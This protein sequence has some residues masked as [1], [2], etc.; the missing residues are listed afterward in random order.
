MLGLT[1]RKEFQGRRLKGTAIELA[2]DK[3]TGATQLPARDFLDITY[4]T[5]DVLKALEAIGPAQGRPLV[6]IG[7]RGQGK[8]HVMGVLYHALTDTAA[9]KQWLLYWADRLKNEKIASFS[10]REDMLVLTESLHRQRYKFLWDLLFDNH[11]HG[12]FIRGKWEGAGDKKT[13][14]PPAAL[15]VELLRKQPTALILDEF[16]TWFDGLT[17]T[18]QYP[19]RN[20]AFNFIQVLSEIAN[21]HPELLVLVVS[22]RNGHTDAYQQI[23]RINPIRVDFKGAD[24]DRAQRDRRR[25]LLHRLF[26]NRLNIAN[27]DIEQLSAAHVSEYLRLSAVPPAEHDRRRRDFLETW[28][29]APH[30]MQLLEDQVLVATEAQETR[31]LIRILADLFKTRG[32]TSPVLTAADFRLD[33]DTSGIAALLDSVDNEHHATLRE[34]AQRNLSAVIDAVPS[35]DTVVPHLSEVIGALWLRSLATG[36][37]A[38]AEPRTLQID[39]TRAHPIDD[40]GFHVEL[41]NIVDNSFNIH[42][43]GDRLVFREEENPQAKLMAFARNDRLFTDGSDHTHLARE[44]RYVI[45]GSDDVARTFR[46]IVLPENWL[47]D[48]WASLDESEHPDRWDDRLPIVVLPED[49]DRLDD[50][51]G[52]WLRDRV[53]RRRNTIRFLLPRTGS[54]NTYR[55]R[56]LVVLARA[57]LKAEEWS[58][59]SAEYRSLHTKY[60]KELRGIIKVRFDRFAL[61]RT[62]NFTDPTRCKFHLEAL[63]AQGDKIPEAI[64]EAVRDDLFVPED[65]ETLVMAAAE[66]NDAVGKL[67]R[68]L[69]EPRPN[70]EDCIPWLGEILTKERII[71]LCSRGKIAINIRGTEFLQLAPGQDEETAWRHMRGRLGTGKYLDETFVLLPQA[72]P[73]T[74]G[75][76]KATY[77]TGDGPHMPPG[78]L[79]NPTGNEGPAT[80]APPATTPPSSST[81]TNIF[82]QSAAKIIPLSSPATSAL[83]L[84]GRVESWGIGPATNVR[85]VA[86]KLDSATG[87]QLQKLLRSL[88][89]G[90]TYELTLE[91]EEE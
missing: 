74:D 5:G 88:P 21:E 28:P 77:G 84:M 6:L 80:T 52:S 59:Q 67:L 10:L 42:Q 38:G 81:D 61:L 66:N 65:F 46:V 72:V 8:S 12:G 85:T 13:D 50:R 40:N 71:R 14:I 43:E 29:F 68:E 22:V 76:G 15:I 1:L 79:F 62:W 36:N 9:T 53:A 19:W 33:D 24:P 27:S 25:L 70:E 91:K 60:Q 48:P 89:D 7:E 73:H 44:I 63:R 30:L 34:K 35:A 69:Q 4:P 32:A 2:N 3:N 11:P 90:L 17:N 51:L 54:Q 47:S 83:N 45:G 78:G 23:H 20:W 37:M 31:D 64:E 87:A 55:D 41:S 86:V 39:I 26:E 56:D 49:V 82:R 57:V 16:Q 18:K 75:V 58:K